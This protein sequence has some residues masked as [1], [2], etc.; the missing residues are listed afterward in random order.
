[1]AWRLFDR[2]HQEPEEWTGF[3]DQGVKFDGR[4]EAPGTFRINSAVQGTIISRDTLILGE[5]SSVQGQIHGNRVIIGGRF[6][7]EIDAKST[8]VIQTNAIVTGEIR[9]PC[10]VIEPG[11]VFD[12]QCHMPIVAP[13]TARNESPNAAPTPLTIP[14]RSAIAQPAAK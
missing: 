13:A 8:V 1:M 4:L 5:H 11:A 9:T 3:L 10:L 6:E 2:K 12:G 7:G 14:I